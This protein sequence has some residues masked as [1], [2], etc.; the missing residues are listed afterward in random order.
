MF[1]VESQLPLVIYLDTLLFGNTVDFLFFNDFYRLVLPSPIFHI[2]WPLF[3][4]GEYDEFPDEEDMH[5]M[6]RLSEMLNAYAAELH[7]KYPDDSLLP[8]KFLVEEMRVLDVSNGIWLS[9]FLPR[10]VFCTLLQQKFRRVSDSPVQLINKAWIYLEDVVLRIFKKYAD[11]YPQLQG[12]VKRVVQDVMS[13]AKSSSQERVREIFEMEKIADYTCNPEYRSKWLSLI[14]QQPAFMSVLKDEF[15]GD[16]VEITGLARINVEHLREMDEA[17][18]EKA[19]DM[20]MRVVA[21]WKIVEMRLVDNVAL[22][23]VLALKNLVDVDLDSTLI[24]CLVGPSCGVIEKML[25]ESPSVMNR[26]LQLNSSI[27]LLGE[28]KDA[29]SSI[30]DHVSLN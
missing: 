18:V 15:E 4:T 3:L 10:Q 29:L 12:Y 28:A 21:Y 19:F 13:R 25:E 30:M 7:T 2:I 14:A 6:W 16:Y 17:I 11:P 1:Y 22:H 24:A 23:L 5:C 26:R 20:K 8:S 27:Q 9:N